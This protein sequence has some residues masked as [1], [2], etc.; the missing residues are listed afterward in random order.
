MKNN[1]AFRLTLAALLSVMLLMTSACSQNEKVNNESGTTGTAAATTQAPTEKKMEMPKKI[2][3]FSPLSEHLAVTSKSNNDNLAYQLLQEK[4]GT[5]I[6]W[7]HP[8]TGSDYVEQF[9]LMIASGSYPDII[10][11]SNWNSLPGGAERFYSDKIIIKLNDL[12]NKY[13][14]DYKK[15]IEERP[16]ATKALTESDGSIYLISAIRKDKELMVYRGPVIRQ[17]WLEK[18]GLN[19]PS[20]VDELYNVMKAFKTGD[21]NGNKK[22]D[23]WGMSGR[24]FTDG[25]NGSASFGIGQLLW[26]F[27]L[28]WDFYQV[29]GKVKFGPMQPEFAEGMAFLNKIYKEGLLDPDYAIQD[30]NKLDGKFMNNEVGFEYGMQPTK[31]NTSMESKDP[32]FKALGIPHLKGRDGKAYVFDS[33]YNNYAMKFNTIAITTACK[34]PESVAMW[35]NFIFSDEGFNIT[36]FGKLDDTYKIVDGKPQFTDKIMK[37]PDGL[38]YSVAVNKFTFGAMATFPYLQS[39]DA[40]SASLHKYG[41]QSI[42]TWAGSADISRVLPN[43]SLTKE[44][45]DKLSTKITDINTYLL[46]QFDKLVNGQTPISDLPKI[47][48]KLKAMGIEEITTAYQNAYDRYNAK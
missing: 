10:F 37:N 19:V 24:K 33:E 6:E 1:R 47:Q 42:S 5:E 43:L 18:L 45:Y 40:Y 23:E 2:T 46:E 36:N 28:N 21:P 11:H 38:D 22:A 31:L 27:G 20:T 17:D 25:S 39:W 13:M 9:N 32:T 48:E 29:D 41:A 15:I 7:L 44:D 4:T 12:I 35:L 26:P 3:I 30:R 14:P 16:S 8:S 34:E